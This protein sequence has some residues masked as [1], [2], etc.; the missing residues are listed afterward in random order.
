MRL[1]C[2]LFLVAVLVWLGWTTSF[3]DRIDQMRGT[4]PPPAVAAHQTQVRQ[5]IAATD[6]PVATPPPAPRQPFLP[7]SARAPSTPS[8]SWMW[9]P[10]HRNPLDRPAFKSG[11]ASAQQQAQQSGQ[12]YW[13]DGRGVRRS[14]NSTPPPP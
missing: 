12:S 5:A 10:A 3:H 7:A 1:L 9:D 13:I 4:Q 14:V 8:G 2:E 11:D 6:N